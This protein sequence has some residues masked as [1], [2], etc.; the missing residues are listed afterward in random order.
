MSALTFIVISMLRAGLLR[1]ERALAIILGADV[2]V[3]LLVFFVALD[4]ELIALYILGA[5]SV[6]LLIEGVAKFHSLG[7]SL[8]GFALI[9]VGLSLMQESATPLASEPWFRSFLGL[10]ENSLWITFLVAAVLTFTIQSA[11]AAIILGISIAS[12]GGMSYDQIIMFTYG[13]FIGASL[14]LIMLSWHLN[15]ASRRIAMFQVLVN[16]TLCLILIP[17]FYIEVWT[18]IPLL[19]ALIR[20]LDLEMGMQIAI[21]IILVSAAGVIPFMLL[22]DPLIRLFSRLWPATAV[23]RA[24]QVRYI[25]YRA[26]GDIGTALDLVTLEQR[27][28]VS[29]FSEYVDAVRRDAGIEMLR[30]STK[31]LIE[32]VDYFLTEVRLRHPEHN[33]EDVNR[34]L[35]RQRLITWL[36]EEL[37]DLCNTLRQL[38]NEGVTAQ[39]RT[40]L[41]E[42]IDAVVLTIVHAMTSQEADD[43][44][45][46]RD[47]T[48]DR[49]VLLREIR[50]G[51][52]ERRIGLDESDRANIIDATNTAGEIFSLLSRLA[53]DGDI[54]S[55]VR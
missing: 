44:S 25:H 2:G 36:E 55:D 18:G 9:F 5:A 13:S 53:A 12:I 26:Y 23:E 19:K 24:S 43:W 52:L 29:I 7:R 27:R 15:G 46:A 38:S 22:M 37:G 6:I 54:Q 4:I 33:I 14:T 8:L 49:S 40:T 45:I 34:I 11:T 31:R 39:F 21:L 1:T 50:R 35:A 48:G 51:Y 41:S 20:S 17:L 30:D 16:I 3:A 10:P 47:V 42:G 32:A 28:V